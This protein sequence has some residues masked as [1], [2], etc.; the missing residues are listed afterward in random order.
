[1]YYSDIVQHVTKLLLEAPILLMEMVPSSHCPF[2]LGC[3]CTEAQ[4]GVVF[5]LDHLLDQDLSPCQQ[6]EHGGWAYLKQDVETSHALPE[7]K[8]KPPH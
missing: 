4:H 6:Q 1:V 5:N 7:V 2:M 8:R 3:R